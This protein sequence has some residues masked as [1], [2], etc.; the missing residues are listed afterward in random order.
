MHVPTPIRS[1]SSITNHIEK[2]FGTDFFVLHEEKSSTV[3]VDI[4]LV[5]PTT[6]RPH[7]T[8]LTSGMSDL[9]MSVPKGL[10]DLALA[11]VCLCLPGEW[12]LA[13]DDFGWRE[14][15]NFWPVATLKNAAKYPRIYQTWLSWEQTVGSV[16]RPEPLNSETDFTGLMLLNPATFP[17]GADT[18]ETRDGRTIHYLALIPLLE[19]EMRFKKKFDADALEEKLIEADITELLNAER[20]SVV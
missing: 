14:P 9:D 5:P 11:E 15:R 10:E 4:H 13:M 17:E 18:V 7:F 12:P 20:S 8:L 16:D 3:H 2:Y 6:I 19:Q 1:L